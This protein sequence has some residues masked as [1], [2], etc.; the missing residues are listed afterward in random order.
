MRLSC[1]EHPTM[2][3]CK[4]AWTH[5]A[6]CM[7]GAL[8]TL[9]STGCQIYEGGQTLPSGYYID[10]DVQYHAPGSEFKLQREAAAMQQ[11]NNEQ[12]AETGDAFAP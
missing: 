10:D 11:Y 6:L 7:I 12:A 4:L 1:K 5:I 8:A 2:K 3:T 9:G